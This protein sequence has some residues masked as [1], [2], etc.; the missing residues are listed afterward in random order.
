M[1][2]ALYQRP[3]STDELALI[4]DESGCSAISDGG[5]CAPLNLASRLCVGLSTSAEMLFR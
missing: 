5:D 2:F 4:R 3:A 1:V